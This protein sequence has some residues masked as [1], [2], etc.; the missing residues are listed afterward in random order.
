MDFFLWGRCEQYV[1]AIYP[2][3]VEDLTVRLQAA[4][5]TVDANMFMRVRENAA[6][7]N[8][9]YFKMDA[10]RFQQLLQLLLFDHLIAWAI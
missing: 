7:R 6:R 5:T 4:V 2:R 3:T 10:G 9:V 1:Y 8:A